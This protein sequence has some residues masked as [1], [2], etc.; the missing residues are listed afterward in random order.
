MNGLAE[1]VKSI[2]FHS[3][4]IFMSPRGKYACLW[5]RTKKLGVLGYTARNTAVSMK[6]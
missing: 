6:K 4:W 5:A 1:R 2:S 3:R